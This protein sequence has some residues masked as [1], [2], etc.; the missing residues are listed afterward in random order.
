MAT[1]E[2]NAAGGYNYTHISAN[3]AGTTIKSSFGTLAGIVVNTAGATDTITVYDNTAASG[4]VIAVLS[5]AV[6]TYTYG[7]SF[8]TGLTLVV[9]GTTAPDIT[10]IWK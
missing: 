1:F 10:V 3:T 9:A 8:N 5:E 4:T 7:L 6:G 2:A